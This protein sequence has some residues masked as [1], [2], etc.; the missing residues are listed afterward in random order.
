MLSRHP[1]LAGRRHV[2]S[3]LSF[4]ITLAIA[5]GTFSPVRSEE[6]KESFFEKEISRFTQL[7][8][9][10]IPEYQI[11]AAQGLFYLQHHRG[12]GVLLP[13]VE[14]LN[15]NVRL[16]VMKALGVCGTRESVEV[17]IDSLADP[18]W[19]IRENAR[20]ALARMTAAA[21]FADHEAALAWLEGSSWAE[22]ESALIDQL[23]GEDSTQA[24]K[25]L[26]AL[27]YVGST[28]SE[29]VVLE[30]GHQLGREGLR[31][32]ARAL[33][34]IGTEKSIPG[35]TLL[36]A[37]IPDAS[38]ALVEIAGQ[39]AEP[40]LLNA[41]SRWRTTRLDYMLNL[42]RVGST[43]CG[44]HLPTLLRGFGLVIYRSRTDDLQ[45]EPTAFQRVAANLILRTGE[46]Q[47]VVDLIL[48]ECEGKRSDEDTPA[49]LREILAGM[50]AELAPGFVRGDGMTVAQPLAAMSHI[51]TDRQFVPRLIALLDH[52]AYIVRI[53]AAE[54]LAGL[55]A[56]EAAEAILKVV[57]T[58]YFFPDPTS[59]ASGKHFDRS[60][61]VRWRGYLCIALGKL[62]GEQARLGLEQLAAD[63]DSYRDIRYGSAVGLRFL[64]SPKSLPVLEQ[65]AEEDIIREIQMVAEEAIEDIRLAEQLRTGK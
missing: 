14:H 13:L 62:G 6:P 46:S 59:Q 18:D 56:E 37:G 35:L 27:R 19:E 28:A 55:K 22:K 3:L 45:F 41:F 53:Y 32:T 30:K 38:W 25:A 8:N 60:K 51:I 34:R 23:A 42:D 65:V 47:K 5:L 44:P 61:F 26:E 39:A 2:T 43:K 10:G 15:A 11:E 9:S 40:A 24:L 36:C 7:A 20:D 63:P 17:L 54:A 58:P 12:E 16:Q 64:C 31:L 21:P 33:E 4:S 49:H 1:A 50:K 29:Q 48:A 52:P 57:R